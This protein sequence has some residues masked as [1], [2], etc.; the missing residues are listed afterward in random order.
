M[1]IARSNIVKSDAGRDQGKLFVVL[2]IEGEYILLADSKSRRV[3]SPKRKK[4]KHVL[5]V[6]DE[7][8]RLSEK[9]K[10]DERISN[11]EVRKTLAAY[12]EE[13]HPDQEG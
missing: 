11:I 1:E 6:S 5:F 2:S 8:T 7:K 12:R 10:H 9:M 4:S 3:E 13:A